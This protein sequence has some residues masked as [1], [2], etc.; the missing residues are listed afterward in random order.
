[1]DAAVLLLETI[2]AQEA[3]LNVR[4]EE[5][6]KLRDDKADKSGRRRV[7]LPE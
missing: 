2:K 6:K 1:M 4:L 5:L 3:A 7:R